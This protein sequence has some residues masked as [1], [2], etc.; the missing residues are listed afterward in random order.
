MKVLHIDSGLFDQSVSRQLSTAI[1]DQLRT[2]QPRL[3]VVYRDLAANP[4]GHLS[5]AALAAGSVPAEQ[6]SAEQRAEVELTDTLLQEFL[7]AEVLVIGAPMYNFGIPSQLKAWFDRVLKAGVT[8]RYTEQGP[9][10]LAGDKQVIIASAR[11]GLY[12][13][14]A[15]ADFQESYL[16][17]L[18]GFAGITDVSVVRAEGVNLGDAPRQQALAQAHA[19][20]ADITELAGAA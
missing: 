9:V 7:A 15:P 14:D 17:T 20:I 3:Q 18:L 16:R 5:A 2:S 19:A 4:P 13:D 1:V 10:G 12:G 6:R 11:G 8:F